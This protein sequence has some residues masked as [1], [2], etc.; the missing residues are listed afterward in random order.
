MI[1]VDSSCTNTTSTK[2][3]L[4]QMAPF[5]QWLVAMNSTFIIDN[6]LVG[7]FLHFYEHVSHGGS[8]AVCISLSNRITKSFQ[9]NIIASEIIIITR[10]MHLWGHK[11]SHHNS[12]SNNKKNHSFEC[13]YFMF[14]NH[15]FCMVL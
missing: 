11:T 13:L 10:D 6:A 4:N 12:K 5:T 7:H 8:P 3:C 9:S 14:T 2:S 15:H 1:N